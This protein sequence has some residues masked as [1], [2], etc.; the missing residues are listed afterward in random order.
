[1][2]GRSVRGN[3]PRSHGPAIH[4][5]GSPRPGWIDTFPSFAQ[6][7]LAR[8]TGGKVLYLVQYSTVQ[9]LSCHRMD[10]GPVTHVRPLQTGSSFRRSQPPGSAITST[11]IIAATPQSPGASWGGGELRGAPIQPHRGGTPAAQ[12]ASGTVPDRTQPHLAP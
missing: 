6:P 7:G 10:C 5:R 9:H 2:R 4:V 1:M 3:G 12:G 8:R 11:T